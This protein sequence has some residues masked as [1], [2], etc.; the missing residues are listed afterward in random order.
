MGK[1][2]NTK[3]TVW[4]SR[5]RLGYVAANRWRP[6]IA[7]NQKLGRAKEAFASI[8]LSMALLTTWF[9]NSSLRN[10]EMINFCCFKPPTLFQHPW[11]FTVI[12][13]PHWVIPVVVWHGVP[14]WKPHHKMFHSFCDS[15]FIY[16]ILPLQDQNSCLS[17]MTLHHSSNFPFL[18]LFPNSSDVLGICQIK[19]YDSVYTGSLR[20]QI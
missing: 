13:L 7:S 4:W 5:Q 16:G 12:I 2:R 14:K 17:K 9:Q 15:T 6:K 20:G 8:C 10:C 19:H 18:H 11:E 1:Q 3:N